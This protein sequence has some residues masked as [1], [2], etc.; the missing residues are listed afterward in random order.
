MS[1]ILQ[2]ELSLYNKNKILNNYPEYTIEIED[3]NLYTWN[4]RIHTFDSS[5]KL[6]NEMEAY[7]HQH[8]Q[9]YVWL[10]FHFPH[11][12]P[13]D[14][15]FIY[16]KSPKLM[17]DYIHRGAICANFLMNGKEGGW[18][19]DITIECLIVQ[20]RQLLIDSN[21][22]IMNPTKKDEWSE[23]EARTAYKGINA[24]QTNWSKK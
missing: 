21:P 3:N 17:G 6:A 13:K 20:L 19:T 8:G 22:F 24:I 7:E 9:G 11:N 18:S 12:Y 4:V 23:I 10:C 15:P 14:P 1:R 5:S 2:H 16:I